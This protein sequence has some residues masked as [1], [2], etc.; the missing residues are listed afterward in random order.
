LSRTGAL[1]SGVRFTDNGDGTGT[2]SGTPA[3]NSAG[4]YPLTLAAANGISPDATQHF[5]LDVGDAPAAPPPTESPPAETLPGSAGNEPLASLS[6][7]RLADPCVRRAPSGR[8]RV[9]LSL[10]A[11]TKAPLWIRIERAVRAKAGRRCSTSGG[12]KASKPYTG[13][14]RRIAT[15]AQVASKPATHGR[16][17][18]TLHLRLAPGLYRITVRVYVDRTHTRSPVVRHLR[19]VG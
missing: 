11:T 13:P 10:R 16:R 6:A 3:A 7:L 17:R 18:V 12:S 4:S 9:L 14:Y 5:T 15:L 8:L 2:L 1:P 19:V